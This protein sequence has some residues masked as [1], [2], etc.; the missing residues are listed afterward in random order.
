MSNKKLCIVI[1][2]SDGP[3]EILEIESKSIIFSIKNDF[4]ITAIRVIERD[5]H[6]C[7][8]TRDRERKIKIWEEPPID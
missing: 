7:L 5:G 8:L 6:A 3:M 2:Y 1:V 4:R